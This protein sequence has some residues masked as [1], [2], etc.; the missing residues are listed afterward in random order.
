MNIVITREEFNS[1]K[2]V[3]EALKPVVTIRRGNSK[4]FRDEKM[5]NISAGTLQNMR[6][7]GT[8]PY[9]RLGQLSYMTDE[10]LA[11]IARIALISG[12]DEV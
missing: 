10:V 4:I 11:I 5:F 12:D 9:S 7:N 3:L 2:E 6:I 8:L 1:F